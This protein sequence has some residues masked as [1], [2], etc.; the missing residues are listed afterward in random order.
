MVIIQKLQDVQQLKEKAV[1]F[2]PIEVEDNHYEQQPSEHINSHLRINLEADNLSFNGFLA[3]TVSNTI[4]ETK[5]EDE[6]I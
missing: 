5:H 3:K 1:S 6:A 4:F 2:D